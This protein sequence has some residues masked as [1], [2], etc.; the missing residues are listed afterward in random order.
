MVPGG[1]AGTTS[2]GRFSNEAPP[3]ALFSIATGLCSR[4]MFHLA[5]KLKP[6]LEA[7]QLAHAAGFRAAEFWT[8]AAVLTRAEEIA[9]YAGE[10]GMR[11]VIHFPNRGDLPEESLRQ[12]A[13]LYDRLGSRAM[14]I[15][16]PMHDRYAERLREINPALRLGV[17]NHRLSIDQFEEW[18]KR[19]EFL[20]LD[21]EHLW[22][23]TL[24]D[25]PP[26]Q[27][28]EAVESFLT[29]HAEKLVHVHLPGYVPG[30]EEHRPMY[31]SREMVTAVLTMLA[32]A[33]FDGLV[34]SE[35]NREYQN[36]CD[37]RMDVLLGMRW[38]QLRSEPA[39]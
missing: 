17:E 8:D 19:N 20:T 39:D 1:F 26:A 23:F 38:Q 22:K 7:L 33:G 3:P 27:L 34:V 9:A 28:L 30:F 12:A 14:V 6:R 15:H 36:A 4:P 13:M 24:N 2:A 37:L 10:L 29:R 25:G 11:H 5:T 21:V 35:V 31:C 32:D 16:R 18:A